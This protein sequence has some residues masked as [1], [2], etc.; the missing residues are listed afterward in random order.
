M[1]VNKQALRQALVGVQKE[2]AAAVSVVA[3]RAV[4][5]AIVSAQKEPD[6]KKS[7]EKQGVPLVSANKRLKTIRSEIPS[8]SIVCELRDHVLT[9]GYVNENALAYPFAHVFL[10]TQIVHQQRRRND[11]CAKLEGRS[12]NP[13]Y[14]SVSCDAAAFI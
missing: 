4:R 3:E 2:V 12:T 13:T 10:L 6:T 11:D 5:Q 1:H 9:H 7:D 8:L 14:L